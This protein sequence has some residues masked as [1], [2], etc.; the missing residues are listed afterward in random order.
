MRILHKYEVPVAYASIAFAKKYKR[1]F[2][3]FGNYWTAFNNCYVTL[4][5]IDGRNKT[6]LQKE[7]GKPKTEYNGSVKIAKVTGLP[8]ERDQIENAFSHFPGELK[9]DLIKSP[10][11]QFF[12][13][14]TPKLQNR[15]PVPI[16]TDAFGQQLNGVLSLTR[17]VDVD[18]PVWSPVDRP[19]YERIKAGKASKEDVNL[20]ARQILSLLYTVRNNLFHGGKR[21]DDAT[22]EQ[23][24]RNAVPL[25]EMILRCFVPDAWT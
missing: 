2:V 3:K 14:R 13:E 7:S 16:K 12:L 5:D 11:V 4:Y 24:V 17:T 10:H 15:V 8:S 25:L 1:P 23:V 19:A 21:F 18:Y 6:S 22:D 9:A 20:L